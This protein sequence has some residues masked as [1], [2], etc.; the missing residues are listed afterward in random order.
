MFNCAEYQKNK[1]S[2]INN[3]IYYSSTGFALI[4][5]DS[6]YNDKIINKK[7]NGEHLLLL[8]ST[9]KK[10]TPVRIT[11]LINSKFIELKVYKKANYP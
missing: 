5:E 8:H 3:K 4:Y 11:N 1:I 2:K 6:L 9:L 10:N 7:I